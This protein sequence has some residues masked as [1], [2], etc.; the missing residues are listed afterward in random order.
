M[1]DLVASALRAPFGGKP[2]EL[3]AVVNGTINT[4]YKVD[5]EGKFYALRVRTREQEYRYARGL[6]K[7]GLVSSLV[8]DRF[9]LPSIVWHD[10][11]RQSIPFAYCVY[12]WVEGETLWDKPDRKLYRE[13]GRLLRGLHGLGLA[14]QAD[15][16]KP[17]ERFRTRFA[18]DVEAA[19]MQLPPRLARQL[20]LLSVDEAAASGGT[21]V[22]NDYSG[23]NILVR[24]GRIAAVI[25]WDN[26]VVEAPALDFVKMKH[27][28]KRGAEGELTHDG[29]LY[30][31]FVEGY[32]GE[33]DADA[34]RAYELLWLCRVYHFERTKELQGL[35]LT[36]GYPPAARYEALIRERLGVS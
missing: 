13:A 4:V 36:R 7:E 10:A 1:K 20:R 22:H 32:G 8:G 35:R 24:D 27:W 18:N 16:L 30:S 21:L 14:E 34:L 25:D 6:V 12:E 23:G 9:P 5:V 17:R 29:A 15:A 33:P 26:A 3:R 2:F 11:S 31:A 28:T 19:A